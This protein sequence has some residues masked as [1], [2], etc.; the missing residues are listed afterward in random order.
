MAWKDMDDKQRTGLV[1][2]VVF[3][4]LIG[5]FALSWAGVIPNEY[6]IVESI[7]GQDDS[8]L[9]TTATQGQVDPSMTTIL[10]IPESP[11]NLS[12]SGNN[13]YQI[14]FVAEEG[15]CSNFYIHLDTVHSFTNATLYLVG[16]Y[17]WSISPDGHT[18]CYQGEGLIPYEEETLTLV[19]SGDSDTRAGSVMVICSANGLTHA[20]EG[21]VTII[22]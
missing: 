10:G 19:I 22:T 5:Y 9:N 17:D 4:I 20:N 18:A 15:L 16:D 12:V 21:L 14:R 11:I 1:I 2:I 13:S 3:G 7:W 6:N 8:G